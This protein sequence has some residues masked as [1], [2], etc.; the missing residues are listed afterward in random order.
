MQ[1]LVDGRIGPGPFA[2]DAHGTVHPDT[3]T[4]LFSTAGRE[5]AREGKSRFAFTW[6]HLRATCETLL[7]AQGVPKEVRAWL[8]SHGRTGVQDKHYDRYSYLPEKCA[9]LEQWG[10]YLDNLHSGELSDNVVLLSK[11]RN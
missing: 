1:P 7:A 8:L 10:S 9:A 3:V 6:K 11:R 5:L 4:K 2:L